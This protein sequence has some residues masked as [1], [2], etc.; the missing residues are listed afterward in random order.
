G[1]MS[2]IELSENELS[3]N[4]RPKSRSKARSR[5]RSGSHSSHSSSSPLVIRE[6]RT[7]MLDQLEE[8]DQGESIPLLVDESKLTNCDRYGK[9]SY[10]IAILSM[11]VIIIP[12]IVLVFVF[13]AKISGPWLTASSKDER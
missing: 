7:Q 8:G 12:C 6:D 13:Q 2:E 11:M 10:L 9:S 4:E 1:K 3:E 5:A